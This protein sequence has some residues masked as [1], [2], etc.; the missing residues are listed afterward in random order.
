MTQNAKRILIVDDEAPLRFL[1]S[2][3]LT[4][5]GFEVVTAANGASAL[6]TAVELPIHAVVLDVVMP[7]MDGFEVCRRLKADPRT[8]AIPVVFLSASFSGDFRRRAFRL[9]GAEFLAKP[10]QIEELPAY[11]HALLDQQDT[12]QDAARGTVVSVVG[13]DRAAGSAAAVRLAEG[14]ALRGNSPVMLIDLEL[15]AGTIGARLQLAGGPNVRVLLHDTGEP[16]SREAIAHVA[17]RV[18]FGLEVIPA[19]FTP[20]ALGHD[21]PDAGR[22][23]DTLDILTGAGYNVVVHVGATPQELAATALRRSETVYTAGVVAAEQ[24]EIWHDTLATLGAAREQIRPLSEAGSVRPTRAPEAQPA[25]SRPRQ[26]ART[27]EAALA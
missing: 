5:A 3:Q 24:R 17:Q 7:G 10:F 26:T 13:T 4:R 12:D 20:S 6:V 8:A 2:K 19:P 11:L 16:V 21:A 15:P 18:H 9:G 25:R 22:L 14:N 27:P 1:L 23:S